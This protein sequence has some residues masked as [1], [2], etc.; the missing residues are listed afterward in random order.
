MSVG[1]PRDFLLRMAS[2][3]RAIGL[4]RLTLGIAPRASFEAIVVAL[5]RPVHRA[6]VHPA[7][8]ILPYP[9]VIE[10]CSGSIDGMSVD[11]QCEHRAAT[12]EEI[13][14]QAEARA[15]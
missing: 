7:R 13:A 14:A 1:T 4:D 9:F 6:S 12:A 11:V 5:D 3:A 15:A 8:D 10:A 2:D